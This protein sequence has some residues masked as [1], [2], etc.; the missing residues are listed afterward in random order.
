MTP[1]E[2]WRESGLSGTYESCA[3]GDD[4]DVL[5]QLVRRGVKTAT[6]SA[7]VFYQLE[8]EDF[9]REGEY[10]VVLDSRRNAVCIVQT[11]KVYKTTFEKVT[12]E[13]AFKEGEGDRSLDYWRQVHRRFFTQELKTIGLCFSEGMELVIE[14]FALVYSP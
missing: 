9:P 8:N 4:P 6:C 7:A 3:F 13:H 11:T 1:E 2:M 5:A 14:E 10:S 12:K